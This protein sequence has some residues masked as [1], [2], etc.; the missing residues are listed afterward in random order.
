MDKK[1]VI[2]PTIL[3]GTRDFLPEEQARR[4]KV[5][6]TMRSI[7]ERFGYAPI[8]TPILSPAE[9]ILGKYGEEGDRLTYHFKDN[10]D[11]DIALPY[12]LTVPFARY[13]AAHWHDLPLPFKRYQI[14]RVWRAEKPQKGRLREFYQC[15]IDVI[16]SDS[17]LVEAEVARVIVEVFTALGIEKFKIKFNSRKLMNSI[18]SQMGI[19]ENFLAA[20]RVIDKLEK[21][22]EKEVAKELETLGV[23]DGQRVLDIFSGYRAME[24]LKEEH[25]SAAELE[26]IKDFLRFANSLGVEEKYLEFDPSLARGLDY[27]TGLI[28]EVV[29]EDADFG[30]ICA[31]GRYDNLTGI[32]SD[33][34]FSGMGVA[35]GFERIMLLLEEMGKT[36]DA[37]LGSKALVTVFDEGSTEDALDVY[38]H[39]IDAGVSSEIYFEPAKLDKQLKFADRKD[40]P[41]VIIRGPEERKKNEVVLKDMAAGKQE[42]LALKDLAARLK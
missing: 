11:R 28:F 2:E 1:K 29:S 25:G 21:I 36:K 9:T 16:G 23:E 5:M 31:G 37:V 7:F 35:F 12:D 19:R 4:N 10:G 18:L 20:I 42:T 27:Y 40:I 17:L 14:Q 15:D 26:D 39:L 13:F 33:K 34:E 32:F 41:Y 22:G 24:K 3:K 8:E 6:E 30:T 38:K